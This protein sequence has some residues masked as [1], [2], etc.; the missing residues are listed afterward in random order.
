M[1][2]DNIDVF[3]KII[4]SLP[5]F[6]ATFTAINLLG[7]V[8]GYLMFFSVRSFANIDLGISVLPY[9][10]LFLF[11]IPTLLSGE[12]AHRFLPSY[13]RKWS[14][15]LALS[16]QF[17]LFIYSLI[18][19]GANNLGNAWSVLW[20]GLITLYVSNFI[21]LAIT[22]STDYIKKISVLSIIQPVTIL[23]AFHFFLGKNL[24]IPIER[25]LLNT[26][27]ILVATVI[28]VIVIYS[29]DYLLNSNISNISAFELTSGLLRKEQA[30]L[31]LGYP[32]EVDV[33]TLSITNESGTAR[34][35][36]P[37]V[38]PGPLGGFGGGS[39]SKNVIEKLNRNGKGF[40][41]HVPSTHRSDPVNP[42]DNNKI[43]NQIG[44]PGENPKASKLLKKEFNNTKFYG[45]RFNGQKIIFLDIPDY[46]DYELAIFKEEI[47]LDNTTIID[48]HQE[49]MAGT[50]KQMYYNTAI[51]EIVRENL[52]EFIKELDQMDLE[53]Y[54]AGFKVQ[55]RDNPF[56]CLVE[57]VGDQRT[58]LYGFEGNGL[59]DNIREL[60][61]EFRNE[62][63][64]V[65][66]FSTDTHSSIHELA[67]EKDLEKP[68]IRR[69]IDEAVGNLS[70]AS[71]GLGNSKTDKI[72][73]LQADYSGLIFSINIIIRL[74][75][76][77]LILLYLILIL[78]VF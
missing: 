60:E 35:G 53:D 69:Y 9:L 78:W 41:L 52:Q 34:I 59:T 2:T 10:I 48:L 55:T 12:L 32:T 65:L 76:V 33:Q 46:D 4:F 30:A 72:K 42:E 73:L 51:S 3:K 75:P 18:L 77:T 21:V 71:I 39:L 23:A 67:K 66:A 27:L 40:F 68:E 29:M 6:K 74:L 19:S 44:F 13:P 62:F 22:L 11:I 36:I 17:I 26:G 63:N 38:H 45:R 7:I 47:D 16:N 54:G 5:S 50:E 25:Y 1:Q 57:E 8:Y 61:E 70:P 28:L 15:F 14:Y 24:L 31:D 64:E 43:I 56:F 58:L 37:W 20:L 49:D